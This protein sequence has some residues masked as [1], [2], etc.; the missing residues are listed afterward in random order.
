M[1][2]DDFRKYIE[3]MIEDYDFK[4][5]KPATN[6]ISNEIQFKK[7]VFK[8]SIKTR[9]GSRILDST[10][11]NLIKKVIVFLRNQKKNIKTGVKRLD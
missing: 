5:N 9:K 10:E 8:K 4:K 3:M 7:P 11:I 6:V 2:T 1:N